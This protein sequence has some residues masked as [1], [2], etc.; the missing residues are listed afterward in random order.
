MIKRG[1]SKRGRLARVLRALDQRAEQRHFLPLVSVFPLIGYLVPL[2]PTQLLL[3]ALSFLHRARWLSIAL[4]FLVATSVGAFLTSVLI[5]SFG[6]GLKDHLLSNS[7]SARQM[8]GIVETHGLWAIAVLALLP[9]PPRSAVLICAFA[10]LS[11]TAIAIAIL[12]GRAAPTVQ[13][14]WISAHAPELFR[15]IGWFGDMFDHIESLRKTE[16]D[17]I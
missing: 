17:L 4:S 1:G 13:F 15:R 6:S 10:G 14:A 12:V 16:E 8:A 5:Q 9:W 2:L 11:P 3:V 7:A